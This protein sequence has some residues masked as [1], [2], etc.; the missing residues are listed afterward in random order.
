MV[1]GTV[2]KPTETMSEKDSINDF[3]DGAKICISAA[4]EL[5]SATQNPEWVTIA[6]TLDA[7]RLGGK[8]LFDMKAMSRLETLMA[9]SIKSA[10]YKPN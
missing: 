5:A 6:E 3:C 2:K 9:A 8:Q 4:K 1:E 7:M 10:A